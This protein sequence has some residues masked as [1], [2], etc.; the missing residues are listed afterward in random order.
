[1]CKAEYFSN[2]PS[3]CGRTE[4]VGGGLMVRSP[5]FRCFGWLSG[6]LL[7]LVLSAQAHAQGQVSF[8]YFY[9]ELG[10][11]VKVVDSTGVVIEY[12]YDKVGNILEIKRSTTSGLAIF[13]FT[14]S[15]GPVT[16]KVTIQGQGFSTNPIE[17]AV[18]FN[19]T[20][21]QVLSATA[22]TLV[23]TVPVGAT[24]G[25][26]SLQVGE[27]TVTSGQDFEVTTVPVVTSVSPKAAFIGT[28]VTN[29]Q[30]AGFNLTG[31]TF[32][33]IPTFVPAA[34]TVNSVSINSA[35]TSAT[36]NLT[37]GN[38]GGQFVLVATNGEGSSDATPSAGNT[39][40]VVTPSTT[41]Q[42]SDGDGFQDGLELLLGSDPFD[43]TS[44]P[45]LPPPPGDALSAI[46]SIKNITDPGQGQPL[47]PGD[48]ISPVFSVKNITNPGAGQAASLGDA[49]GSV[50]SVKNTTSPGQGQ[51]VPL[52]DALSPVFSIKN[53]S[54]P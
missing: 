11:L 39:F 41:E 40:G 42:D 22:T 1:M 29:F 18:R 38:Q 6:L 33:F 8:Q 25:K 17:N 3:G 28:T 46:V 50:F 27:N 5:H 21:A 12:V 37:V 31:S 26:I 20:S 30:V 43:K 34:I 19:G 23:V 51:S 32:V 45:L 10:Q 24:T 16:T 48:A 13:N 2:E 53:G 14:P 54:P 49:I 15:R 52:G 47:P 36:L 44:I 35:G 9:D 7:G 4:Q